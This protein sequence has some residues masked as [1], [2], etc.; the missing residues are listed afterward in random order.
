MLKQFVKNNSRNLIF[1]LLA[2]FGRSVNRLYENRN[3]NIYSNGELFIIKKLA[4]INPKVIIDGGANIGKYCLML[5]KH[6]PDAQIF[7][8]EP[9]EDTF[10]L[11][12]NNALS[13][14]NITPLNLGLYSQNTVKSI[15]LYPSNTHNSLLEIKGVNYTSEKT[16]EI[17]LIKGDDFMLKHHISEIDFLKLD[18]EGAEYDAL[19]GFENALKQGKIK[20]IQFEYGY[21]N[22]SSK[23]L[24]IDFYELLE[25]YNYLVGK[26]YPK[27]VD[28]R[29]YQFKHEDFIGPNFFA[30]HHSQKNLINLLKK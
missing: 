16:V 4:S 20:A 19:L 17:Q 24:L 5:Q 29:K 15:N 6:L 3:H 18:L 11:L 14:S 22:I 2:G 23:K 12:K 1:K 13:F 8:F 26:I 25:K 21:I 9:V 28:F 10:K 27:Y 30:V 7:S